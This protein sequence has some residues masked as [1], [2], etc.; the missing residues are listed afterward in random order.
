MGAVNTV[1]EALSSEHAQ[2]KEMV[3]NISHEKIGTLKSL[4]TP[5]K[6][7]QTPTRIDLPPP[8]LGQHTDKVLRQYLQLSDDELTALRSKNV[9][10]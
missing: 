7:H 8:M 10:Q 1:A 3:V 9:I 5:L 2:V 4:G 6:L